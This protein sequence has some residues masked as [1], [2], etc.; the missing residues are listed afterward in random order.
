[1][2]KP[3]IERFLTKLTEQGSLTA[4]ISILATAN[5][6]GIPAAAKYAIYA[7]ATAKWLLKG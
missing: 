4:Y 3:T 2:H 1:M 5:V 6:D 7:I